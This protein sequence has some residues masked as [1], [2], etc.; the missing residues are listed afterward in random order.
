MHLTP[1]E[2]DKLLIYMV[3]EVTL[4]RREPVRD[5]LP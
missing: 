1:R 3:A 2:S 4:K 5:C